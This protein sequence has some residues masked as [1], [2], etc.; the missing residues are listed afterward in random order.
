MSC[1]NIDDC[2]N[3]F[4]FIPET[5][6]STGADLANAIFDKL[7]YTMPHDKCYRSIHAGICANMPPAF[8]GIPDTCCGNTPY[9]SSVQYCCNDQIQNDPCGDL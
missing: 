1:Q 5:D 7:S 6:H 4:E 8:P 2:P 9:V 3:V